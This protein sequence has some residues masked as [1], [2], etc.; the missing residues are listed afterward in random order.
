VDR[1]S[2]SGPVEGRTW[3]AGRWLATRGVQLWL[4]NGLST[5]PFRMSMLTSPGWLRSRQP[6]EDANAWAGGTRNVR[7]PSAGPRFLDIMT[8]F[9]RE[10]DRVL[11]GQAT[12]RLRR[13]VIG[14]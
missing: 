12:A 14:G 5:A 6:W 9:A 4:G 13:R 2:A 3:P 10:W 7:L 11:S 1:L 8:L